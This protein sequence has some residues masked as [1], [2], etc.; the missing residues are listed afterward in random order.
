MAACNKSRWRSVGFALSFSL[1]AL[2][3]ASAAETESVSF[4]GK[5]IQFLIGTGAGDTYDSYSRLLSKYLTRYLPGAPIVIPTNRAGAGSLVA[6]NSMYNTPP[7]DGTILAMG[8][9]FVPLMP[10]L[11]LPGAQFDPL[12][13]AYIGSLSQETSVCI[14]HERAGINS[15]SEARGKQLVVGTMGA[16]T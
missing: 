7:H 9:R 8:Q 4:A 10:L 1:S 14:V 16:G 11:N 12:K 6:V 2:A 13:M 15:V 3:S 5:Q